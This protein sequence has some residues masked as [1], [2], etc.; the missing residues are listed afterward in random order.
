MRLQEAVSSV[1]LDRLELTLN[2]TD[3]MVY[4]K[5]FQSDIRVFTC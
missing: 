2:V 3:Q 5:L 4:T 1:A